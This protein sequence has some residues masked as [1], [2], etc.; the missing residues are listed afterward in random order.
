MKYR[1]KLT[2]RAARDLQDLYDSISAQTSQ[3]AF[4]WFNA[5]VEVIYSLD[6]FPERG[7]VPPESK[8]DRQLFF[9][10]KPPI[11]RIVYEFDKRRRIV[12]V[13]H[14]RHGARDFEEK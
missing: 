7:A 5:L 1:V 8:Y 13:L 10:R 2:G 14:I 11:Y 3:N 12:N 6:R 9:G 4:V